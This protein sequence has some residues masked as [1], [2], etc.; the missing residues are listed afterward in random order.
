VTNEE[1]M[2]KTVLIPAVSLMA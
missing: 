2:P 1:Q